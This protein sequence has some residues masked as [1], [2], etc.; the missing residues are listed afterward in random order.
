[1][2]YLLPFLYFVFGLIVGSFLNVC[3]H[4]IPRKKSIVFPG[5]RCP[6]CRKPIRWYDNVP[7]ISYLVLRGKCRECGSKISLRY[8]VVELLS[9]FTALLAYYQY[10]VSEFSFVAF[11][12][13]ASLIVVAFVDL[14]TMEIPDGIVLPG[15]I[16]GVASSYV[17]PYVDF[18]T[19]VK[20]AIM[21]AGVFYLVSEYFLLILKKEGLGLGD[22]K[23]LSYIASVLSIYA[24][25]VVMIVGA[26]SGL[27]AFIVMAVKG[28]KVKDNPIPFGPFLVAGTYV[29]FLK[30]ELIGYVK[31]YFDLITQ[32]F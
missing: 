31:T 3:I 19:S 9:G 29:V 21:T 22:V 12:F 1:M 27:M 14:D 32:A 25:P 23:L 28:K 5:S 8:P 4:R 17:N 13:L 26:V 10:G 6:S 15:I 20:S 18:A 7:V 16:L 30:P 11:A 2:S 24:V